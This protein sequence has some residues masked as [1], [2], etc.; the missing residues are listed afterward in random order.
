[1][2]AGQMILSAAVLIL[3]S[4]AAILV[5]SWK[6]N[7]RN[8]VRFEIL[9]TVAGWQKSKV[10]FTGRAVILGT[11]KGRPIQ[12]TTGLMRTDRQPKIGSKGM[13]V[14]SAYPMPGRETVYIARRKK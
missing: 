13:W 5:F 8:A 11:K 10:P 3:C 7:E 9:G 6:K 2:T 14:V 1:M 4:C 12:V